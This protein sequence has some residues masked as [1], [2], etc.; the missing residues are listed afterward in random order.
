MN[1]LLF[2]RYFLVFVLCFL[3]GFVGWRALRIRLDSPT[4]SPLGKLPA[5]L[6]PFGWVA[7]IESG[8]NEEHTSAFAPLANVTPFKVPILMYHYVEVVTDERDTLRKSMAVNPVI[9]ENQLK[10]LKAKGYHFILPEALVKAGRNEEILPEK[11]IL[12]TFDDGYRDFYTV[13]YPILKRQQVPAINYI[14]YNFLGKNVN[15]MTEAEVREI[16][17]DGLV[18]IGSHT[19]D[20]AYLT[21]VNLNQVRWELIESRSLLAKKFGVMVEDFA[22]PGGYNDEMTQSMAAEAGYR[23]AVATQPGVA[24]EKS[25][26]FHL[27]RLRV[28]NL[29]PAELLAFLAKEEKRQ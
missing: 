21:K 20:H 6:N 27:P 5:R 12:L 23:T 8:G 22:Y 4:A 9:F 3:L 14:I 26:P 29:S 10:A 18:T 7:T 19:M 25:N 11:P 1:N 13:A 2:I 28:G 17:S 15:Y 24:T 16:V